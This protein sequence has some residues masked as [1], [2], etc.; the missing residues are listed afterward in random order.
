MQCEKTWKYEECYIDITDIEAINEEM[1]L[2]VN[3]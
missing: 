2:Y 1:I 3:G